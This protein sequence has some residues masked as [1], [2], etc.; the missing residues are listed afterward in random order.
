MKR[1][2]VILTSLILVSSCLDDG[3]GVYQKYNL[4]ADFQYNSIEFL[5]DSTC[6]NSN[7]VL[8]FGYDLLN[9]YHQ[10][11]PGKVRVDG[12]F[13][14]SCQEMPLSGNTEELNNEYR[15]YLKD[16]E[17]QFSNTYAV[18][19]QNP[20]PLLMPEHDVQFVF[21]TNGTCKPKGMYVTNTV[22]VAEAIREKFVLG[23]RLSLK[24]TGYLGD[25]KTGEATINLAD[26]SAQ[27]DSIVSLWT[28]F[29]L[30]KLGTVEYVEFE[31]SSTNPDVPAY[32]C[33]DSF[34]AEVEINY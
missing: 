14:L 30:E 33:M 24:A 11:D 17:K 22:A 27:K 32:F 10:L 1:F 7:S 19:Y 34:T 15:C 12:G 23:D 9:F 31:V 18:Y 4:V 21:T 28:P 8:G 26:F 13:I 2:F 5:P 6:F 25:V 29:A 20:D 16:L 3:S